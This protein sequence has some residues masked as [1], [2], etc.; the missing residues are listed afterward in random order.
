VVNDATRTPAVSGSAPVDH[1]VVRLAG[2]MSRVRGGVRLEA[3]RQIAVMQAAA[4]AVPGSRTW[5]APD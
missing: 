3:V 2:P 4:N 5:S 1:R